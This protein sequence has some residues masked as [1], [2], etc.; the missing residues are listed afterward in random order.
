MSYNFEVI[1]NLSQ[2]YADMTI[3]ELSL[4]ILGQEQENFHFSRFINLDIRAV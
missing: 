2:M 1:D 3:P 4:S